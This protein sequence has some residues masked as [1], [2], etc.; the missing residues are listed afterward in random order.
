MG[1]EEWVGECWGNTQYFFCPKY[2]FYKIAPKFFMTNSSFFCPKLGL[3][4][5]HNFSSAQYLEPKV[6]LTRQWDIKSAL[7]QTSKTILTLSFLWSYAFYLLQV[8]ILL[9]NSF[10]LDI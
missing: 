3:L 8:F 10:K 9:Y 7:W 4:D 6:T 5:S 2:F 1:L